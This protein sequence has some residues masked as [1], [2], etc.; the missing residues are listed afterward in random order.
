[1]HG[2]CSEPKEFTSEWIF[3]DD[4]KNK[5]KEVSELDQIKNKFGS[6]SFRSKSGTV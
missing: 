5:I 3:G 1:M 2:L 4:L 6:D